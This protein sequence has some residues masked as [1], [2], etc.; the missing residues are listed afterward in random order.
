[1]AD[2]GYIL[3]LENDEHDREISVPYFKTHAILVEFLRFSNEVIPFLNDKLK[4]NALPAVILL[5]MNSLPDIGLTVLKEIKAV[6]DLK[7]IPVIVLGEH[8]QPE[9]I[10]ECYANGASTFF[11]KPFSDQL[12][13]LSI[14]TF[15]QYWFEV[16]QLPQQNTGYVKEKV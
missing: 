12:T 5:S 13:D 15:L 14:K 16:A 7:H 1:M 4:A 6:D 2:K 9:L 3:M 8:T 11:N 10:K